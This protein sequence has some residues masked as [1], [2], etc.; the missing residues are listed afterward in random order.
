M[1]H[2]ERKREK[3]KKIKGETKYGS[4]ERVTKG[5]NLNRD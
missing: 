4:M 1:E 5:K 2:T 3:E